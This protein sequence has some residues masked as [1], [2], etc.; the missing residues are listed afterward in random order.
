MASRRHLHAP[1]KSH[2]ARIVVQC[3]IFKDLIFGTRIILFVFEIVQEFVIKM[4]G[5][6]KIM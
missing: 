3:T 2:A 4:W 5:L 1:G 6:A